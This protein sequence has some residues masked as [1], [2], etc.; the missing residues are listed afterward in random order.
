MKRS[1]TAL[2]YTIIPKTGICFIRGVGVTGV[3][4]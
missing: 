4:A 1:A 3:W 2:G